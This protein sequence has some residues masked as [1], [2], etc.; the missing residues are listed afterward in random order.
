HERDKEDIDSNDAPTGAAERTP[1]R[2]N[3]ASLEASHRFNRLTAS[4]RGTL[5]KEDYDDVALIGGG[6]ANNDDRDLT[7]RS[8]TGRLAYAFRPGVQGFVEAS[9]NE[10]DFVLALDDNGLRNG[11]SGYQLLAGISLAVSGKLDGEIAAGFARQ[12]PD[13]TSL[14]DVS[15]LILNGSLEWRATPLTTVRLEATSD[16]NETTSSNSAGSIERTVELSLEHQLRRNLVAGVSLG[17]AHERFSGSGQV[18]ET[19][20]LGLSGAYSLTR[21]LALTADYD[22]S[23]EVS[24]VPASDY[25]EN[26]FRVGVRLRR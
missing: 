13:E 6:I 21:W 9:G 7:E 10:R 20:S 16:V 5:S 1:F 12:K 11:S 25:R 3:S 19:Y 15:G 26:E 18:D 24:S 4:L 2:V 23:R 17:Y 14:E 8:F 22:H